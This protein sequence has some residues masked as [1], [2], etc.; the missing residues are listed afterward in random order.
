MGGAW[1]GK[2]KNIKR[3]SRGKRTSIQNFN[4]LFEENAGSDYGDDSSIGEN[5]IHIDMKEKWAPQFLSNMIAKGYTIPAEI[6]TL[7]IIWIKSSQI[8]V[9]SFLEKWVK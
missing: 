5:Y 8:E 4:K 2:G 9:I 3:P 1:S 6:Q 7:K